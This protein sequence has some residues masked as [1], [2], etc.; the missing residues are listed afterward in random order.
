MVHQH[1]FGQR[2]LHQRFRRSNHNAGLLLCHAVKRLHSPLFPFAGSCRCR[3]EL[4]LPTRQ[5]QRYNAG[6]I[7]QIRRHAA[8]LSLITAHHQ[9]R[10]LFLRQ[11]CR[12]DMGTVHR[13]QARHGRRTTSIFRA[14]QQLCCLRNLLQRFDQLLHEFLLPLHNRQRQSALPGREARTAHMVSLSLF[15]SV[16]LQLKRLIAAAQ[17]SEITHSAA[18]KPRRLVSS[19]VFHSAAVGRPSTQAARS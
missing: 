10:P 9:K 11:Q 19:S 12:A 6:E 1:L 5:Q 16:L 8:R 17:P 18:S 7:L 15:D 13:S 2:T 14:V 4:E 3:V